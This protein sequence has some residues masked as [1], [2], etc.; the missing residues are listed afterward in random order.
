M[1]AT[2]TGRRSVAAGHRADRRRDIVSAMEQLL[3]DQAFHEVTVKDVMAAAKLPRTTFYRCF[4]DME[5]VLLQ[6]VEELNAEI[7]EASAVWLDSSADPDATLEVGGRQ[8]IAVFK[9]H[10]RL[11][12][13][14]TEATATAAG[15]ADASCNAVRSFVEPVAERIRDLNRRGHSRVDHPAETARALVWMTARYLTEVYGR[16]DGLPESVALETLAQV[17]RR[18]LF[19]G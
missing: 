11:L 14:F 6:G 10:S 18:T 15:V 9:R 3:A 2:T 16:G 19:C 5:G 13:A 12:R 8:L 7:A 17:W 4:D 1:T